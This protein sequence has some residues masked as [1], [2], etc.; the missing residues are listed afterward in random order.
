MIIL[1]VIALQLLLLLLLLYIY[2][3]V[4]H[5]RSHSP[6][7]IAAEPW[8]KH[9]LVDTVIP[10]CHAPILLKKGMHA[11]PFEILLSNALSESVE[12]GLG[13]IR[14]HLVC[15]VH[16][17]PTWSPFGAQLKATHPVTLVR[18]PQDTVPRCI[19]QTHAI[20][21]TNEL[22]IMI[23]SAHITPGASLDLSF[24]FVR[25][26]AS[27]QDVT[28]K[29]IERQKFRA[30]SQRVTRILHHEVTLLPLRPFC[31]NNT[32][33]EQHCLF[34][35]PDKQTLEVHP[36]TTNPNIRVRHWLQVAI[37]FILRPGTEPRE[38]V[39]DCPISVLKNSI[40]DYIT[41]PAYQNPLP[42]PSYNSHDHR[43]PQRFFSSTN[44]NSNHRISL[45]SPTPRPSSST[46]WLSKLNSRRSTWMLGKPP[47][48]EQ[49]F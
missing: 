44:M 16:L 40:E 19:T 27:V 38:I 10:I 35:I 25:P 6:Y 43:P 41:L 8:D 3:N 5:S 46:S 9:V 37:R 47:S 20:D 42:P 22:H 15:Q 36:S 26:V 45:Q 23:D 34:G 31:F 21:D 2:I 12:C 33:A 14:Y 39:M 24:Y 4:H 30:R 18:L 1:F 49:L 48:Y 13:H 28:V 17:K 7:L 32:H 11:F 29:L